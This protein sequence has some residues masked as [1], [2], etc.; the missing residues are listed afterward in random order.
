MESRKSKISRRIDIIR[1]LPKPDYRFLYFQIFCFVLAT[2]L[3]LQLKLP[4]LRKLL[5]AE[6]TP[7]NMENGKIEY[8]LTSVDSIL[9]IGWPFI[10]K[11]CYPRGL[12]LYYYLNRAG[13]NVGLYFGAEKI[14]DGLFGHCWLVKD[15]EPFSE[16]E[17]PRIHFN[18]I[19]HFPEME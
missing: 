17:D 8:I 4:Q 6:N 9:Q 12:T 7:S 3:L 1:K 18:E 15:G 11:R 10:Q 2:P 19:Y 5:E 14:D 16:L 13:F